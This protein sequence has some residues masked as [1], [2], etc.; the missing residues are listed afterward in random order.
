MSTLRS[1]FDNAVLG[2]GVPLLLL[3][4]LLE[5]YGRR[6]NQRSS[7]RQYFD[8]VYTSRVLGRESVVGLSN[9]VNKVH[10]LF[11]HVHA[12][13][14]LAGWVL[15]NGIAFVASSFMLYRLS[16]RR[17]PHLRFAYLLVVAM[18]C[19]SGVVVTPYDFL[20][21]ALIIAVFVAMSTGRTLAGMTLMVLAVATRES[22]LLV[23]PMVLVAAADPVASGPGLHG[24]LLRNVVEALEKTKPILLLA[25]VGVATYATLKIVTLPSGRRPHFVQHVSSNGHWSASGLTGVA[26][27]VLM[28]IIIRWLVRVNFDHE[29]LAARCHLLWLLALPY[30]AVCL[31]WGIWGE[32]PRLVMP[33]V[34]GEFLIAVGAGT[35]QRLMVTERVTSSVRQRT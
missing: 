1:R 24:R 6:L 11:G 26:T 12:T 33:L 13:G 32:A 31:V 23:V 4:A 22:A 8:G 15:T 5:H 30:L 9:L 29:D 7:I 20:S 35:H 17:D 14:L 16:A 34:L 3:T 19:A 25:I 21:Y 28:A 27:A 18:L 2:F 10:E